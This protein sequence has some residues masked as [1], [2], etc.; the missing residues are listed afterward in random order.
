MS[1]FRSYMNTSLLGMAHTNVLFVFLTLFLFIVGWAPRFRLHSTEYATMAKVMASRNAL[2]LF[3]IGGSMVK[4]SHYQ[5]RH[6][7]VNVSI[8][9]FIVFAFFIS[10]SS[11]FPSS[12]FFII[13]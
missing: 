10:F 6:C 2:S 5:I 9:N 3:F 11:F 8:F 1:G 12:L 4:F 13:K 7:E